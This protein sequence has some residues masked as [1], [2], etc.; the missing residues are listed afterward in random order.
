M[1]LEY[2]VARFST[3]PEGELAV[4]VL[5]RHGIAARL[6]DRDMATMNPDLLIAIGGVRVVA[7]SEQIDEA[8]RLIARVRAGDLIDESEDWRADHVPGRVGEL[9]ETEI[10]GALGWAK[11]AGTIVIVLAFVVFPLAGCLLSWT[12]Q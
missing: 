7:P 11:R 12:G 5:N 4:A 6:P 3:I 10:T 9:D 8:R 2:E 1:R